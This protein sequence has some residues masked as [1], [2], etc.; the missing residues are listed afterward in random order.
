[1]GKNS[2]QA[3]KRRSIAR[4][5]DRCVTL[6]DWHQESQ[7]SVTALNFSYEDATQEAIQSLNS[8]LMVAKIGII[9]GVVL[10]KST[11]INLLSGFFRQQK[12][13]S[14]LAI[15]GKTIPHFYKD[16]QKQI[17]YIP[18]LYFPRYFVNNIAFL[19]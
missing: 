7:L 16:W 8:L 13:T 6:D 1:M 14:Q 4:R 12:K 3:I 5:T 18:K 9:G 10:S 19:H 17:L 2:F 15:N 11:L